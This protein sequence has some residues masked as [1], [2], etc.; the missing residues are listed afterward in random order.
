LASSLGIGISVSATS[1]RKVL[2]GAGLGPAGQ[3]RGLSW[4][5]F[6]R[7][8]A[9]SM[10]ACDFFT[11]DTVAMRRIHVLFLIELS[12][13]RVHLA[14]VTENPNSEQGAARACEA[15]PITGRRR[16]S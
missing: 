7:R 14:G 10:I 13:R 12:T 8:Q 4:H 6:I 5:K 15:D 2:V 9:Q 11:V 16:S 1:V 3:R